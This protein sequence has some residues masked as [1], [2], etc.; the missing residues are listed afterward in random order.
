MI[1]DY[2]DWIEWGDEGDASPQQVDPN[3]NSPR[4]QFT[5]GQSAL[6]NGSNERAQ[7]IKDKEEETRRK[8]IQEA[9]ETLGYR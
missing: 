5:P 1:G 9:T 7:Q 8:R 4:Y 3:A 6:T 2:V